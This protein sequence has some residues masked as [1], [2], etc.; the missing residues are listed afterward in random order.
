MKSDTLRDRVKARLDALKITAFEAARRAGVE[1]VYVYDLLKGKKKSVRESILPALAEALE[2]DPEYL[3]GLQAVPRAGIDNPGGMLV[4]GIAEAGVWRE[5]GADVP[6]HPLPFLPDPR[7]PS[8][9]QRVFLVRGNHA[10]GIGVIDGSVVIAVS[11]LAP[12]AGD[13]VV[14]RRKGRNGQSETSLRLLDQGGA[15]SAGPGSQS[16][17]MR[18]VEV[19]GVVVLAFQNFMAPH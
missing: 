18:D 2:C 9:S 1:R 11:S 8:A 4:A 19:L 5:P 6:D 17:A 14:C 3:T 7:Y 15:L 13:R 12:R 16:I 10:A